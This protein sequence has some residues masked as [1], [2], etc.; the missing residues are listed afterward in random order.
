MFNFLV[1]PLSLLLYNSISVWKDE[2]EEIPDKICAKLIPIA[3]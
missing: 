3:K 1:L 2:N